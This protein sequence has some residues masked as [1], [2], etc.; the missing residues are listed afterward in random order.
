[1]SM[2][3]TD[4]AIIETENQVKFNWVRNPPSHNAATH[5]MY[6]LALGGTAPS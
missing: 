6:A 5:T 2:T 3:D 1:M 4:D